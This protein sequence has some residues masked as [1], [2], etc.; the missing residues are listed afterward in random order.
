[1]LDFGEIQDDYSLKTNTFSIPIPVED[2]HVCRQL[3]LGKTGD[4]LAK[5][6]AIG[7]PGSGEHDHKTFELN[8]I[9]G[10]VKGTIGTPASGQPD[11]PDP[12]QNSAGGGALGGGDYGI[13]AIKAGCRVGY[14]IVREIYNLFGSAILLEIVDMEEE[15]VSGLESKFIKIGNKLY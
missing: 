12:P 10:P 1:M 6:Q 4:I 8:S 7:K 13:N 15:T 11:P 9:H 5:T 2:Y 14:E 3:T